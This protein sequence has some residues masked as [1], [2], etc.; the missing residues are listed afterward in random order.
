MTMMAVTINNRIAVPNFSFG[1][2]RVFDLDGEVSIKQAAS[3]SIWT[4]RQRAVDTEGPRSLEFCHWNFPHG[5]HEV[6]RFQN[7]IFHDLDYFHDVFLARVIAFANLQ[8]NKRSRRMWK[9][10]CVHMGHLRWRRSR[11]QSFVQWRVRSSLEMFL[12][13][14]TSTSN[15]T[16][17]AVALLH[18]WAFGNLQ[19]GSS[20]KC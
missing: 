8:K 19:R 16:R 6:S 13:N 12:F 10:R 14:F 4:G 1:A 17:T 7:W 2:S 9:C 20:D 18:T 11:R 3:F 15:I 5:V